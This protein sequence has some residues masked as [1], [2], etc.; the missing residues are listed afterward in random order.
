MQIAHADNPI[1][2]LRDALDAPNL[3]ARPV[4]LGPTYGEEVYFDNVLIIP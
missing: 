3:D 1:D 2:L 4:N